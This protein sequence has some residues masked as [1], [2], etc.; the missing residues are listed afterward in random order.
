MKSDGASDQG[1]LEVD[2][3]SHFE[4]KISLSI[5]G[6]ALLPSLS[7]SQ[8][9][10]HLGHSLFGLLDLCWAKEQSLSYL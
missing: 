8:V 6:I 5:I 2:V 4:F 9:L 3:I 7:N 1:N 10:S